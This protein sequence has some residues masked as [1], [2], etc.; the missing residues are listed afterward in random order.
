MPD[1]YHLRDDE[2]D[3]FELIET[4]W[5]E[6]VLIAGITFLAGILGVAYALVAT[7]TFEA[8]IRLLPADS[9][10]MVQYNPVEYGSLSGLGIPSLNSDGALA[11]T[12]NQLRST[13][14]VTEFV[15]ERES[16]TFRDQSELTEDELFDA[17]A[18]LVSESIA[19][20]KDK[21]AP[22]TIIT[23][24]HFDAVESFKFLSEVILWAQI[25][26]QNQR[27]LEIRNAI[28]RKLAANKLQIE[29]LT[30]TYERRLSED[31]AILEEAL[32]IA[33]E[34]GITTNQ[35]GVFLA[36]GQGRLQ[37]ANTLYLKGSAL[38]SAEIEALKERLNDSRFLRQV[39][40]LEE[41]NETLLDLQAIELP[42]GQIVKVDKPVSVPQYASAPNK[43]LIVVLAIVLGGMIAVLY[44]LIRNAI[45]NRQVNS[46]A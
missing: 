41:E 38:L 43:K 16:D 13:A 15:K 30:Q 5:S 37:E 10:Q 35:S 14:L 17:V 4:L 46:T 31:L 25:E 12:L 24:Q 42:T 29:R 22:Q 27:D 19:I 40:L 20:T 18:N 23:Y 3:L 2:I 11:E 1:N 26:V 7:P 39:R 28:E 44:V 32:S 6:K 21:D 36:E 34:L 45:R 9:S 33:T 8:E